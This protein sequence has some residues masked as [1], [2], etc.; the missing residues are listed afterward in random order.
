MLINELFEVKKLDEGA[1]LNKLPM[2]FELNE[3]FVE[4]FVKI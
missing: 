4:V 1:I 3:I 2:Y